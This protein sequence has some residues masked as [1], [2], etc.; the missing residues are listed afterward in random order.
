MAHARRGDGG[1]SRRRWR[2]AR[3]LLVCN[4]RREIRD[5]FE[6]RPSV[7][8]LRRVGDEH[9]GGQGI[10][11]AFGSPPCGRDRGPPLTSREVAG[12]VADALC[13]RLGER[14]SADHSPAVRGPNVRDAP[15]PGLVA[16]HLAWL[17][18]L[19]SANGVCHTRRRQAPVTPPVSSASGREPWAP[20][21]SAQGSSVS[22]PIAAATWLASSSD[23]P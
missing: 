16:C 19:R 2:L 4:V 9:G 1:R 5:G 22:T 14:G 20:A 13:G 17:P 10:G 23:R 15:V 8:C 7:R 6:P 3:L 12:P 21:R 11:A 18:R